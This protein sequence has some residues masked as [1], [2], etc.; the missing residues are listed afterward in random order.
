MFAEQY[1][2]NEQGWILFPRD[3][4]IR[5]RYLVPWKEAGLL[6][7][8][9][10]KANVH[11]IEEL[12]RHTTK[13]GDRIMDITAGAGTILRASMMGRHVVAI[14]IAHHYAEW[15]KLSQFSHMMS[16]SRM[17][18]TVLEGDCRDFLPLKC[19]S[20][21]FSPP[22]STAF[23]AG[24]G[25]LSRDKTWGAAVEQYRDDDRNLGNLTTFLYNRAMNQIYKLCFDSLPSGGKISLLIKDRILQ[26]KRVNLGLEAVRMMSKAG[27]K[28]WEWHQWKPPGSMFVSIKRSKGERVVEDESIVI[29]E[30]P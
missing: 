14:E 7:D 20:I 6:A 10:A 11:L 3:Q 21:I 1:D 29:M 26:G 12:V 24:G 27:F 5:A 2:R 15:M 18:I 25:I 30:K 13:P 28:T 19:D 23:N 22:Y 9:P 8:H 17:N 4:A 16:S